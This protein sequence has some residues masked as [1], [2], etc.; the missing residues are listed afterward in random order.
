MVKFVRHTFRH[1]NKLPGEECDV[2]V[3]QLYNDSLPRVI[4]AL[5]QCLTMYEGHAKACASANDA[6]ALL[7]AHDSC[8]VIEELLT[9]L[10]SPPEATNIRGTLEDIIKYG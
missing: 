3:I 6:P 9:K 7:L 2:R 5:E 1:I 4:E 10:S 8:K